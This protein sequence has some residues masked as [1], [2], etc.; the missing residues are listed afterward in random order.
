MHEKNLL[1]DKRYWPT[2]WTQFF[3]AFNDNVYKNALVMLI[4]YKS[5]SLGALTPEMM[6]ALCGGIFILPFFL[7]SAT[8]GQICD[9]Y[10]KNKLM[11][12]IKVWEILVMIIGSVGFMLEQI[13]LLLGALFLMGLQS[14]FFGPVKY[15]ILPELV[16]DE[17]LVQGN[18]YVGMGTFVAILLGTILGGVLIAIPD[19]GKLY[20]SLSVILFAIIG[21][22]FSKGI[23]PLKSN[24]PD[25]KVSFGIIKPTWEI[26]KITKET[27]SIF[28]CVLG[29]SWFW[30]LG[31]ALLSMFPVYVKNIIGGNEHVV[32][33]FL[34]L[35]SIG[36]ALGNIICERLSRDGLELGLV[37]LGSFGMSLFIFDLFLVG[38]PEV[39]GNMI[40]VSEFFQNSSNWRI[41]IDL[42]GLS[43]FSGF[44]TV[45]LYT[46]V[47]QYSEDAVRSRVIAGLNII[48]ALFMVFSAILLAGFYASG[49]TM[50][51]IFAILS[52]LN[53]L[54]AIY[55]YKQIPEFLLRFFC[56]FLLKLVYRVK[57]TGQEHIPKE[58]GCILTCNHVSFSDWLV[59]YGAIKRPVRFVMYYKFMKIPFISLLFK[60]AGIIPIAGFKED[61]EILGKAMDEIESALNNGDIICLFPEGGI[62]YSGELA[63][64]RPG[65]ERMLEKS[66]VPVIP[67][68]L[69]GLWGSYLSR[70]YNGRA[71][72]NHRII[73]KSWFRKV[74]LEVFPLWKPS[75]VTAEKIEGFTRE[76]LQKEIDKEKAAS[77]P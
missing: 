11:F 73:F 3:G 40:S 67:M 70:K 59:V 23:M 68:T 77:N 8:A 29:I 37:P 42:V 71:F 16:E 27:K 66:P 61:K 10:P 45:P 57:V 49:F 46:F 65:I 6:V 33:L 12:Y 69:K 56:V 18:A 26:M 39:K 19:Q 38:F 15:S 1:I 20:T 53:L 75:E 76:Q 17:E 58:G 64:F 30:F 43:I 50:P 22:F 35:F 47:Q 52:G 48:N 34:A 74:D 9:K 21:T 31:A 41:V 62:T 25:L 72:S 14:T 32:V 60:D 55:I 51:Q 44:F 63:A 28:L 13:E 2:Y 4:T 36:V 7:F 24:A 54:V 5:Y